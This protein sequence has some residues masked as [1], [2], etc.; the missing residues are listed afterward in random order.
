MI[1]QQ[2]KVF[3][4]NTRKKNTAV[5]GCWLPKNVVC[6]NQWT[7]KRKWHQR[8][9]NE[10]ENAQRRFQSSFHLSLPYWLGSFSKTVS[11]ETALP[12]LKSSTVYGNPLSPRRSTRS[13]MPRGTS[14]KE[15]VHIVDV[16]YERTSVISVKNRSIK[17][18]CH[19]DAHVALQR[20]HQHLSG[21]ILS[22]VR[23][24]LYGQF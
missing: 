9:C 17:I 10:S 22:T 5:E 2:S 4:I 16:Q 3:A 19:L 24:T 21:L 14:E 23:K 12:H 6:M 20:F 8:N 11:K 1:K 13:S 15:I 7:S 18:Y